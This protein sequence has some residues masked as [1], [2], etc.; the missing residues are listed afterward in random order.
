MKSLNPK[1]V[2]LA[3]LAPIDKQKLEMVFF[4]KGNIVFLSKKFLVQSL[5]ELN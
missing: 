1:S 5:V 3:T 4:L 2:N